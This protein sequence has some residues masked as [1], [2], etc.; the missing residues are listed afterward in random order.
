M[1]WFAAKWTAGH[2]G[3]VFPVSDR[4]Q[5]RHVVSGVWVVGVHNIVEYMQLVRAIDIAVQL[6]EM[7]KGFDILLNVQF[8]IG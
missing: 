8:Q 1:L 6:L 3:E 5:S 7:E 4:D 2:R